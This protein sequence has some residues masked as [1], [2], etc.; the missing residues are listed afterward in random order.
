MVPADCL[1][2]DLTNTFRSS[3]EYEPYDPVTGEGVKRGLQYKKIFD[4]LCLKQATY[5]LPRVHAD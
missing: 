2:C 4:L 3:S 5:P 1:C